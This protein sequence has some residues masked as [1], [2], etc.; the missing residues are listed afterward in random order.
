MRRCPRGS[1]RL[2]I[3][4]ARRILDWHGGQGTNLYAVG[5][6]AYAGQ[7]VR[8]SEIRKAAS[9]LRLVRLQLED[10][11]RRNRLEGRPLSWVLKD[12]S[13]ASKLADRLDQEAK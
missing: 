3:G 6:G 2:S 12:L 8:K 13:D 9:E 10:D 11:M 7:C 1:V 4:L 5:S